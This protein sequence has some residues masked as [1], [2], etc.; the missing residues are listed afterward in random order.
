MRQANARLTR[1]SL[2][3]SKDLALHTAA[4]LWD[5]A[6]YNFVKPLKSLRIDTHPQAKRF[7]VR[8]EH[9]TP[10]MAAGLVDHIWSVEELLTTLPIPTNSS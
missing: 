2:A 4:M 5:D 10:A 7:Q 9:A 3:F 8:Y 6:N 1:K